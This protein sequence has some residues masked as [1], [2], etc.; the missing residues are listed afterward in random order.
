MQNFF[1]EILAKNNGKEDSSSSSYGSLKSSTS[2]RQASLVASGRASSPYDSGIDS[3]LTEA[4]PNKEVVTTETASGGDSRQRL[5]PD[6]HA[7]QTSS[8]QLDSSAPYDDHE[9]TSSSTSTS[10]LG[11]RSL[12]EMNNRG[13]APY[14]HTSS[15]DPTVI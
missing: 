8:S 1:L 15:R 12:Q 5:Q 10:T 11:A 9:A 13:S 14:R 2:S 4:L 7:A 3:S 6:S